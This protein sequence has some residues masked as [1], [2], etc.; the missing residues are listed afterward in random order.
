MTK[1]GAR[2]GAGRKHTPEHLKKVPFNTKL[3]RWLRDWLTDSERE[4]SGPV[5]IEEA[6]RKVH[7]LAPPTEESGNPVLTATVSGGSYNDRMIVG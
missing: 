3:P 4:K 5:L 6:L 1:G 2:Q 7:K